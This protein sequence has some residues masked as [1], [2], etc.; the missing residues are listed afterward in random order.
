M[1]H[2]AE[3]KWPSE[4]SLYAVP[5]SFLENDTGRATPFFLLSRDYCLIQ[6]GKWKYKDKNLD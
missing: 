3:P 4:S 2:D 5:S 6:L 1:L